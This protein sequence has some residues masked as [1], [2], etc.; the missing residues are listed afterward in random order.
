[1]FLVFCD[2]LV[3]NKYK[4]N[5]TLPLR[6]YRHG[7]SDIEIVGPPANSSQ[8]SQI[9]PA[10]MSSRQRQQFQQLLQ[11][12]QQQ[13]A[14]NVGLLTTVTR[15]ADSQY[16]ANVAAQAHARPAA[17]TSASAAAADESNEFTRIIS[18]MMCGFGDCGR[19]LDDTVA[20]VERIL[21]QQLRAIL[22]AL[23]DSAMRRCGRPQPTRVDFE[24]LMRK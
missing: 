24:F 22:N 14:A 21:L 5:S 9:L 13:H 6:A 23:I 20:L 10:T 18:D 4:T 7:I 3:R 19:P 2:Y 15:L 17:A 8:F 11:Q 12:Q 16:A 1:M